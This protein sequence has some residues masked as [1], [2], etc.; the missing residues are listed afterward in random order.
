MLRK[1]IQNRI[2]NRFALVGLVAAL[3]TFTA[4]Q[5]PSL[6]SWVVAGFFAVALLAL[7]WRLG[8]LIKRAAVRCGEIEE[9]I[10][11]MV[12]EDLLLWESQYCKTGLFH[13]LYRKSPR[14]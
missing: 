6:V 8:S 7:W 3:G 5:S 1:E 2:N 10:N 11:K 9:R 14:M 13:K 12:G 4:S